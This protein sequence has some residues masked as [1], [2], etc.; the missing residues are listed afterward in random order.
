MRRAAGSQMPGEPRCQRRWQ[1]HRAGRGHPWARRSPVLHSTSQEWRRRRTETADL[2]SVMR[3]HARI[4][5]H[6]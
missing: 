6:T 5:A 1:R 4:D 3:S 2:C